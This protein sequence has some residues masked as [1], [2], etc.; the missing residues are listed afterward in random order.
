MIQ[1]LMGK[2]TQQLT[3]RFRTVEIMATKKFFN[4][5]KLLRVVSHSNPL[6]GIVTPR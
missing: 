3:Q 4:L 5:G 6:D 1:K 2:V